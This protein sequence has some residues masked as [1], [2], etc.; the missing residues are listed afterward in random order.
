M[1]PGMCCHAGVA[2]LAQALPVAQQLT[3]L[4]LSSCCITNEGASDLADQIADPFHA[5]HDKAMLSE[6]FHGSPPH[7]ANLQVLKLRDNEI[8]DAAAQELGEAIQQSSALQDLDLAGNQVFDFILRI[9]VC[10]FWAAPCPHHN[11]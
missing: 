1:L 6:E 7:P 4:D 8:S 9:L 3:Y 10:K 11:A 2:K 5:I